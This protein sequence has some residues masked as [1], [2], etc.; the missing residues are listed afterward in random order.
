MVDGLIPAPF[1]GQNV[2]AR[3]LRSK[4]LCPKKITSICWI[5]WTK[6]DFLFIRLEDVLFT[7]ISNISWIFTGINWKKKRIIIK[8]MWIIWN[9]LNIYFPIFRDPCHSR[10]RGLMLL[11]TFTTLPRNQM[12]ELLPPFLSISEDITGDP[13]FSM[14]NLS[15]RY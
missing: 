13:A 1:E 15:L 14:F 4:H 7:I 9:N 2:K 8:L 10:C 6:K 3:L 5:T 12:T 11:E